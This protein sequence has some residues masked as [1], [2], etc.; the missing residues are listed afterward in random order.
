MELSKQTELTQMINLAKDA[1]DKSC[2]GPMFQYPDMQDITKRNINQLAYGVFTL[3]LG[4]LL[5]TLSNA[6]R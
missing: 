4:G 2:F 5:K 1:A 6:G 3:V